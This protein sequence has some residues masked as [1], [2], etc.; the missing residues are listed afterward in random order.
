[1]DYHIFFLQKYP[2]GA[3]LL[4]RLGRLVFKLFFGPFKML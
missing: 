1:M 2:Q 3:R 4:L